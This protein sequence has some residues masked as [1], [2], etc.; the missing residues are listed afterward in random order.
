[1][2]R[3]VV[4][5]LLVALASVTTAA[6]PMAP[7]A[8]P[9]QP[10]AA[11][12]A[13]ALDKLEVVGGV[14]Y[15]AAHPDDENTLLLAW[16]AGEQLL[17]T[18]YLS[19]TRGD[20]GQNLVGAEQ[21]PLLGLIRTEEL[22]AAR[23][24]DGAEQLF[25]RARDFGYSKRADEALA[26]WGH[27]DTLADVVLAIRR[28]KPDVVITRFSPDDTDT[29]GHHTASARLAVEAFAKAGDPS[30]HPEQVKEH[31]VWQPRRV[32]WNAS[33]FPGAPPRD[34]TSFVKLDVGAY[35]AMRGL[36]WGELAA[37]SRSMHKSQGFGAAR[38]RGPIPEYFKVLAG[39]PIK[40]S[41]LDGVVTRW[42]RVVGSGKLAAALHRAR[43]SFRPSAPELVIPALLEARD[44]LDRLPENPWKSSKRAEIDAAV[45]ACAGL[46]VEVTAAATSVA[47][48]G[49]LPVTVT[50]LARRPATVTFT[51]ARLAGHEIRVGKA[52]AA[53]VPLD[54]GDKLAVAP[55]APLSSPYWLELPP[56]PGRYPVRDEKMIGL[57]AGPAPLEAEVEFG[58]SGRPVIV[59]R[60][61]A[62]KWTDP[63]M[64]ERYRAVEV[65]PAVTLDLD[66]PVLLFAD[67]RP[68]DLRVRV[69][70]LAGA[71]GSV[72][73][74]APDGFKVAPRDAPF[75]I[76]PSGE[77]NVTFRVT[78][79]SAAAKALT[80]TL[81]AVATVDGDSREVDRGLRRIEHDHIPVQTLLPAAEARIVRVEVARR[82]H[83]VGYLPGA[84]DEIPAALRELGYQVTTLDPKALTAANLAGLDAIVTGVRAWNVEPGL[85]ALHGA[86]MD[87]VARG[88]TLVVQYNTNS[89]IGPAPPDLG[90][91]PFTISHDRTT[92][93]GAPVELTKDPILAGPNAITAADFQGWVQERGLY[94]ADKWDPRYRAPLTMADPGEKPTRGALLVG[95]HGK[96][97]F[98]YTGLSLFRQ[99]PAGVPGAYRLLVNLLEHG[100]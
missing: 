33:Q 66:A 100:G 74:D 51:T 68:R 53:G 55:D 20:G 81:R 27:D 87:W 32:V 47:R 21:G 72:R 49:T 26:I 43:A 46:F 54:V 18:G 63:V 6:A 2:F 95:K 64:G 5:L 1:M 78:P 16:L 12:L 23:R 56:E 40:T 80:G 17:R 4:A 52:L 71:S 70:S 38:R 30:F 7:V 11:S 15:V 42:S 8:P 36:S 88:G 35:N 90:P 39:E 57:P 69:R 62:Y 9:A 84:G 24:V 93:E 76:A 50:A 92:D 41:P 29:H 77:V 82:R 98:I 61:V 96:G 34:F 48:G 58:I 45:V 14:L 86:L 99:L 75:K 73:L 79:P 28:F 13:R 22:L 25:T 3:A 83:K 85:V 89:R 67:P 94:F 19:V 59:R 91:F 37:E 65:L 60:A 97:T 44:E 31:G 10:D